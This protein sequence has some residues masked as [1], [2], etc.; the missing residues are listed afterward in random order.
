MPTTAM[1]IT[2]RN[3]NGTELGTDRADVRCYVSDK[4]NLNSLANWTELSR[5]EFRNRLIQMAGQ[6]P[7]IAETQNE[8]QKHVSFFIHGYNN[9][10]K[11]GVTRY[12]KLQKSLYSDPNGLGQLILFT[13][14]SNGSTFGYLPDREDARASA[15]DLADVFVDLY[16]H[17]T[18]MQRATALNGLTAPCRAKIS[19]IAHSMG[20]YVL[21]KALAVASKRVNNPQ[22]IT[23]IHQVAMVAADVDNDLF[24]ENQPSE[25]DGSLMANLCYRLGALFTG[26]DEVLGASA[27]LKH[28]GKRRLGRSGLADR[29]AVYD[30]VFDFDVTEVLPKTASDIHSAVFEHPATLAILRLLLIGRD[31]KLLG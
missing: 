24:Q 1:M 30:N 19:V 23:L 29:Q 10:W 6:F 12:R 8:Q 14:P 20:N 22:L 15:P 31:R 17:L 2:N 27:G 9:D 16:E 3:V 21:Q 5:D 7:Q 26:R 11:E 28:F 25:S 13:W 18:K 4:S